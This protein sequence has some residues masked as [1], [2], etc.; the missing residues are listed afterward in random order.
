MGSLWIVPWNDPDELAAAIDAAGNRLAAVICEVVPGSGGVLEPRPGYLQHLVSSA[1]AVGALV[2]F[3]EVMTGFRLA[4]GGAQE[5]YGVTPDITTLGKVI[6]GGMAVAAFG[7]SHELMR[8]EA[9]NRVIH[10]GTYTGSPLGLAAAAA[11][12]RRV[13]AEPGLYDE[14]GASSALLAEGIE[15][16]FAEAGVDGHV[17]RVGSMLQPFL[18][19]RPD[20]E[21]RDVN[22][23]AALQPVERYLAFCNGLE[24]RG[25]YAHRYALGRWFVSLAHGP[26][27]IEATLLAVRG[28]VEDL[29][30]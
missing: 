25:V 20:E 14:L 30:G 19:V 7:G 17:R 1:Q 24:A 13:A 22:G 12:L 2:I 11:V 10:G 8:W 28:A 21:P 15:S 23:A 5:W 18:A 29:V 3:D 27:E 6:G 26:E 16:A 9:E 4:A